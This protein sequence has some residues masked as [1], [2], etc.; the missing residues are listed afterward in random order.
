MPTTRAA[1]RAAAERQFLE[2]PTDVLS[3]VLYQLPL[4]HDIAAVAPTCHAL[5]DAAKLAAKARPFSGEVVTLDGHVRVVRG[6]AAAPDGRIITGSYDR[7]V[8]GGAGKADDKDG[9]A[10]LERAA[11]HM[12][13]MQDGVDEVGRQMYA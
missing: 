7:T 3:L 5:S 9:A 11:R 1:R 8:K 12:R 2:L 13:D 10:Y 6:V 4:A